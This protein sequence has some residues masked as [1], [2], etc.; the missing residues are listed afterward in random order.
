MVLFFKNLRRPFLQ[1]CNIC[2]ETGSLSETLL[3]PVLLVFWGVVFLLI[4]GGLGYILHNRHK[5]KR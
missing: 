4:V 5:I 2:E 1:F 3:N